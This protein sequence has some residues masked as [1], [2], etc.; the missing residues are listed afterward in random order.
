MSKD[1]P[2]LLLHICCGPCATHVIEL[3]RPQYDL[4][5]YFYNPNVH[6]EEEYGRRLEAMEGYARRIGLPFIVEEYDP[7]NWFT[8]VRG[9]E[10]EPEGGKRCE[11]CFRMRLERVADYAS[12]HG[13]PY[14]ATTL[15]ISP[16]KSAQTINRIGTELAER[17]GL[18]FH[19]ADFKQ[20]D[21]FKISCQMSKELGL[22][23]QNYCG[24][25]FSQR[26]GR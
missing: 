22:Y 17:H 2:K 18:R 20:E 3:L 6:P 8:Q 5:G 26:A 25:V 1:R 24:C 10:Q 21:G 16:H 12:Q 7:D 4:T 9:L 11:V 23:R 13:F 19:A 15:S 14:F